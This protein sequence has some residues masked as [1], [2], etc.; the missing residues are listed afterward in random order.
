[1]INGVNIIGPVFGE[2]G[3]GE[4]VRSLAKALLHLNIDINIIEYPKKGNFAKARYSL[5]EYCSNDFKHQ[6]NIFC[7]PIFEIFR[8]ISEHGFSGFDNKFNIGY[9][10]WELET[11]PSQFKFMTS[12]LDEV[13]ASSSHTFNAYSKS[14][15]TPVYHIPLV[16]EPFEQDDF[17]QLKYNSK[18]DQSK[19]NFLYVFDSNSTYA[20]KN[21]HDVV[22]AFKKAF[23]KNSEASLVLKTMNYQFDDAQLNIDLKDAS[24]ITL[25]NECLSRGELFA[26]Y[27]ACD[28]Y[29]SLHKAEGFGRT[30]AEAMLL[31]KPVIVS[32]YSGNT[33]FCTS[34]TAFLVEG[35]LQE[36]DAYAYHFWYQ[37]KW[38]SSELDSAASQMLE[39]FEN[40]K[41][42]SFRVRN[43]YELISESFSIESI[44]R[45]I[46]LRL[47]NI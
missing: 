7:I 43:A 15:D 5:E 13:W 6:I 42:R 27:K 20:R 39:C 25:I 14:L 17:T 21:P 41:L 11:W 36:I 19:F 12:Y 37:N 2:F 26:L 23:L 44:A 40:R 29:V 28:A 35:K 30:I 31:Q 10:P 16:V 18:I 46:R 9:S 4:D 8:F 38:F 22:K 45:K 32:N 3:I 34:N 33:D 47:I 24:N 1:M